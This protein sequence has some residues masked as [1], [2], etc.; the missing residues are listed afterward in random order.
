MITFAV[1]I[2]QIF[3][4][5]FIIPNNTILST[6]IDGTFPIIHRQFKRIHKRLQRKKR[7]KAINIV[8]ELIDTQTKSMKRK[9]FDGD[10]TCFG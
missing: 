9:M 5:N 7:I 3:T 4:D 6:D 1:R 8:V 10:K 2:I